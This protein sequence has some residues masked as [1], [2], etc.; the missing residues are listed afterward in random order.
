MKIV[1]G[2]WTR[3]M[4]SRFLLSASEMKDPGRMVEFISGRLIGTAYRESTLTGGPGVSEV[5]TINLKEMDCFTFLDYV[6]AMRLSGNFSG[7]IENLKRVRYRGGVV[8]Y[9]ERNH[10]FTDWIEHNPDLVEDCTGLVGGEKTRRVGIRLNVMENGTGILP[11]IKPEQ[12]EISYI[13]SGDVDPEVTG[14]MK[15]GDYVGIYSTK[16]GLDASHVG[17]FIRKNDRPCLR[18]ASSREGI[19]RVIDEPFTKYIVD[20]TG[21]IVL[22]PR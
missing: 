7:F 10:F 13:P 12:R 20:V 3:E 2:K 17:I 4:I 14:R 19:R 8:S 16:K 6:E 18:H 11:G 21:I 5:L 15:T 22:R 9:G 1:L